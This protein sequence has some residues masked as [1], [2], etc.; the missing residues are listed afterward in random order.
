MIFTYAGKRVKDIRDDL[1]NVCQ[2]SDIAY[3]R[4]ENN[5]F[6]FHDLRHTFTTNARRAR[7]HKNVVM[8]LQ[9]HSTGGDMNQRYVTIDDSDLLWL[10]IK[11][12]PTWKML[13]ILLTKG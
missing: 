9:G 6:I 8:A 1:K 2:K 11:K 7:A 5:G 4:F 10:S 3:G 13:T 12:K